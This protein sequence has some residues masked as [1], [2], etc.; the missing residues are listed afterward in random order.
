M[1]DLQLLNYKQ[2]F[3]MLLVHYPLKKI[4]THFEEELDRT[5]NILNVKFGKADREAAMILILCL[6]LP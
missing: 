4:G 1:T 6:E 3:T 2:E 5:R